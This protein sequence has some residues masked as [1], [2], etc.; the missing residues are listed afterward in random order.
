M[1][2]VIV[3][4]PAKAK[5]IAKYL[6]K[7]YVVK[8]SFGHVRDLPKSKI[9]VDVEN[10]F[11]PVYVVPPKAKKTVAELTQSVAKAE[12]VYFATDEDR[13]GEAIAWHLAK[14]LKV[15]EKTAERITF[16]EITKSAIQHAIENPRKLNLQLVDAQQARRILDRLVGYEL[17]PLLWNKIRRGLSAGRVQSVAVR[18]IVER[19]REI[20]AFKADEFWS[21]E[22]NLKAKNGEFL[23]KLRAVDEQVLDKLAIK[24]GAEAEQIKKTLEGAV[25]LI[26]NIEEKQVNRS[27][28]PPFTT[29]TLQQAASNRLGFST[30][31]TMM[32]AQRLY[33][34][35]ELGE[36]GATGL[37]TYMRTDSLNLA[38]EALTKIRELI[39]KDFGTDY[40]PAEPRFYKNK[41]RGAQEAHE[42]IRPTDVNLKPEFVAQHVERDMARLYELIWRRTVACQ[43]AN[44]KFKAMTVDIKASKY[45]FRATGS[46]VAFAGFL[47]IW[48]IDK[49]KEVI[50]PSLA[51]NET[52]ELLVLNTLQHFT[53]P[54]ARYSEA[55]L[56]KALE[57]AGIGRPST[58]APTIDTV[59]KRGY[60]EKS[61]EDKRFR[62]TDIGKV[63]NDV[64]VEHFP[65]IVD[66]Q[67]TA[68]MEEDLDQ[69]ADGKK[70]MV[71]ILKAF[72]TP[73]KKNL[74]EKAKTLN[75][76]DIT[77]EKTDLKCPDCGKPVILRLGRNGKFYGCSG[78]PD[79]KY[80]APSSEQEKSEMET[81]PTGKICPD[82]NKDLVLKRGR[83]GAFLG[84]AGYP[85][86]KHTERIEKKV[87]GICPKCN[88]GEIVERKS[89]RG[90]YFY[91]CNKYPECDFVLWSK[92]TGE[93]C[94]TCQ[95]LLIFGK[96]NTAVCSGKEC[97]FSKDYE[98]KSEE[99]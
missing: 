64:L 40:L 69:I 20:E 9:G 2:L 42:A 93:K 68:R 59:Q 36:E 22:A 48:G 34:G 97:G 5:T 92:P 57:E 76:D 65:E 38:N 54:P 18:L 83:F 4:S 12:K 25:W 51:K 86:C 72:Y 99:E 53:Q 62:P 63:V 33:E 28:L 7:G 49:T 27:P 19:E 88:V 85:E 74:K 50:L 95:S 82:C 17:S 3:E 46:S 96:N 90:K 78:Y 77:T 70:E 58:Y 66:I 87:G 89:K 81:A 44:A 26:D 14:I 29:S 91:G 41:S 1:K 45:Y 32:L 6:G 98:A 24:S 79:C 23:A 15:N 61:L 73:F 56:V 67:F 52:L 30:K 47:Q 80:T 94:P 84:C 31:K 16:D 60:V 39:Q 13:E 10:N 55:S 37:I 71:P 11:E 8:A 75:K 35:I 21:V 43:T